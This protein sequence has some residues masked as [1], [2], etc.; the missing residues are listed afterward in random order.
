MRTLSFLL[1]GGLLF[2]QQQQPSPTFRGGTNV[3]TLDVSV[4]DRKREPVRGLTAADFTVLE[5]GKA[6]PIVAF[7]FVEVPPVAPAT[8]AW[9]NETAFDV[10]SNSIEHRR[11]IV[12]VID[13]WTIG[14]SLRARNARQAA[15]AVID[16]LGPSDLAAVVFTM[17]TRI[18]QDFTT[19]RARLRAAV[20]RTTLGDSGSSEPPIAFPDALPPTY[21]FCPLYMLRTLSHVAEALREIPERRKAIV[22]FSAGIELNFEMLAPGSPDRS[23]CNADRLHALTEVFRQV[24]L[25]NVNIYPVD[26]AGLRVAKPGTAG[27]DNA[28]D[29]LRILASNTGGRAIVNTNAPAREM[30]RI[31]TEN[32]AYYLLGYELGPR[33][34]EGDEWRRLEVKVNRRDVEVRARERYYEPPAKAEATQAPAST[35]VGAISGVLPRR[36]LPL[37]VATAPI[38][39]ATSGVAVVLGV[40]QPVPAERSTETLELQV[41]AFTPDGKPVTSRRHTASV[42]M[43]A[44]EPGTVPYELLSGLELKPGRYQL[45][46]GVSNARLE[47]SGSVYVDVDV[48]DFSRAAVSLSGVLLEQTP[49]LPSAPAEGLGAL[50]PVAPTVRR[51]F[52]RDAKVTAF[53]R[54]HRG[55]TAPITPT[56][57]TVRVVDAHDKVVSETSETLT[58]DRFS[59]TRALDIRYPLPL[60]AR[61]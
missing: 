35:T 30:P 11:M 26:I 40:E 8:A 37:W 34:K 21:E 18:A 61:A 52:A 47:K 38:A 3:L 29:F 54:V 31:L 57:W 32:G 9:M 19:D 25:A 33:R 2:A 56:T 42:T 13:Q 1:A 17:D 7:S 24:Q 22:Y 27:F 15:H 20:D 60:A 36:E 43:R 50:A 44:G 16:G 5:N 46:I 48:P 4:V 55:G 6:Q 10:R 45:R 14:D 49:A 39:S 58:P 53:V 41:S 59:A 12:L 28:L 51:S 23:G